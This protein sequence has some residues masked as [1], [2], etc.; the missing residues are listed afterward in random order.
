M[1]C[2]PEY[3]FFLPLAIRIGVRYQGRENRKRIKNHL[4]YHI[5]VHIHGE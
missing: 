2:N 5:V 3:A 4:T 1:P